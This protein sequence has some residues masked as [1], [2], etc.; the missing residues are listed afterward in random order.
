M[1]A[2]KKRRAVKQPSAVHHVGVGDAGVDV[3]EPEKPLRPSQCRTHLR[4]TVAAAYRDIVAGFVG[5]AKSGSCQHLK[6]ATEVVESKGRVR[7]R[8]R[9]KGPAER[10]L[11]ELEREFPG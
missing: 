8:S 3:K 9:G 1:S 11:E 5:E 7:E 4:K 2:A 10:M 6:M